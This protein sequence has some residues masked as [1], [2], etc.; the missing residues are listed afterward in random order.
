[1]NDLPIIDDNPHTNVTL[2]ATFLGK[3]PVKNVR[4]FL[5]YQKHGITQKIIHNLK[6]KNR[7]ELGDY[8]ANWFGSQLKESNVFKNID[9][10]VPVPLHYKKLKKRGYNQLS[11]FGKTLANLLD[12]EYK[13][14]ILVKI[15][16]AKTQTFKKRFERFSNDNT[17]F[18]LSDNQIFKNKH[19]L[20]IDDVITTGATLQACCNELLN[21]PNI[22]ISIA[23]MAFTE[24]T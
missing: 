24:K 17:S 2:H 18:K 14:Q 6:Y 3:I 21:T 12:A 1:M 20:L 22:T 13:P 4:S 10:I 23:T 15:S 5:Y 8:I 19:I 11:T 7:P 16:L 9:Y